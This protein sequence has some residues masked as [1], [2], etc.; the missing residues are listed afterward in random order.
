MGTELLLGQIEDTNSG[1]IARELVDNGI[2]SFEQR[3]IGDNFDRIK[4]TILSM[5][6]TCDSVIVTGGLGPTHDDITRE[7]VSEIMGSELVLDKSVEQNMRDIFAKRNRAMPENNLRQAMVSVG[8]TAIENK[9]GT[10]PGLIC[11]IILGGK[12]K[13][14]FLVP[15]VPYELKPMIEEVII[16]FIVKLENS[17]NVIINRTLK[18]W[19]A[20]ESELSE[21]LD[22]IIFECENSNVK[23]GFLARGI[24]GIYIKLSTKTTRHPELVE[25]SIP[26]EILKVEQKVFERVGKFVYAYDDETME[27]KVINL[28]RTNNS[29]LAI[30]E[31][32]TGGLVSSRLVEIPGASDI[33]R[34][35]IVAYSS[36][37]KNDILEIN[38]DDVYSLDCA[39]KMA[40]AIRDKFDSDYAISTTGV[41]G[42]GEEII[43]GVTHVQ[44]ECYIGIATCDNSQAYSFKFGGDRQR[45]RENGTITALN[46]LREL[47]L[48]KLVIDHE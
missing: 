10:A 13:H 22:D 9:K 2:D 41:S 43:N 34:G 21:L 44:G 29:S 47:M 33:F 4:A 39:E 38:F 8:A 28:L 20:A 48:G 16:P 14:V 36:D 32:F 42:P 18:C 27:S 1:Y 23:L 11:P 15:G 6:E 24:E 19:G 30:A 5:L 7:V 35:S 31:S 40:L 25:G 46:I 12:T 3:K 45:V 37:I 26:P 17:S